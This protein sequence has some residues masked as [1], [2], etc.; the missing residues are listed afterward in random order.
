ML[1]APGLC[2]EKQADQVGVAER[3]H[4]KFAGSHWLGRSIFELPKGNV[5][6]FPGWSLRVLT[7]HGIHMYIGPTTFARGPSHNAGTRY[8]FAFCSRAVF[9]EMRGKAVKCGNFAIARLAQTLL[10]IIFALILVTDKMM[11]KFKCTSPVIKR[12]A[13]WFFSSP[14]S[15]CSVLA[16]VPE[17]TSSIPAIP[18]AWTDQ[19]VVTDTVNKENSFT[20]DKTSHFT[21]QNMNKYFHFTNTRYR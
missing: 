5:W 2:G 8:C 4:G 10:H 17:T 11:G 20:M 14:V 16:I 12:A 13:A 6:A 18:I 3:E 9:T 21:D 19:T 15:H 7:A 1:R